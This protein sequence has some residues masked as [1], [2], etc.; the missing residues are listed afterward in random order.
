MAAERP[1]TGLREP[2]PSPAR[3]W[4][5]LSLTF[6]RPTSLGGEESPHVTIRG[7]G[8]APGWEELRYVHSKPGAISAPGRDVDE[9]ATDRS[10]PLWQRQSLPLHVFWNVRRRLSSPAWRGQQGCPGSADSSTIRSEVQTWGWCPPQASRPQW[11]SSLI[12]DARNRDKPC[13]H[14]WPMTHLCGQVTAVPRGL[15]PG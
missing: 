5:L 1:G 13:P 15:G 14:P 3:P 9:A 12:P 2:V 4:N 10:I 7:D 11:V 8:R 6:R